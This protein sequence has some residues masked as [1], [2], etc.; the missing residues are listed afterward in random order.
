MPFKIVHTSGNVYQ[1]EGLYDLIL[2]SH[3]ILHCIE[4]IMV[5]GL[6]ERMFYFPR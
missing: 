3:N 6:N 1:S 4:G 5:K 2:V